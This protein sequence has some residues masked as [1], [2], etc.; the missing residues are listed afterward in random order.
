M[1]GCARPSAEHG[2]NKFLRS[3][4]GLKGREEMKSQAEGQAVWVELAP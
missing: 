4:R 3:R 2:Q 1:D